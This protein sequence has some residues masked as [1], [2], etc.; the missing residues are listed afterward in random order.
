VPVPVP[1]P[2]PTPVPD[3]VPPTPTPVPN[4]PT[5]KKAVIVGINNYPGAQLNGC[6]NDA[7][8]IKSLIMD[9]YQGISSSFSFAAN[10]IIFIKDEQATTANINQ[11]LSW[12]VADTKTG[13]L[14][15]FWYSG[16]GAEYAGTDVA[17]QPDGMNQVI[18][19]VDFDWS[20]THMIKDVQFK[21]KFGTMPAGVIFN[22]G[23]DS[24]HSGDLIKLLPTGKVIKYRK[25]PNNPIHP[26]PPNVLTQLQKARSIVKKR[27]FING[28]L[29]V[30]YLA[31]CRYN[32]LSA[33]TSDDA[34][35]PCGAMTHGFLM[36]LKQPKELTKT[37]SAIVTDMNTI[38][39]ITD[40]NPEAE[41]SRKDKLILQP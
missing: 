24:C 33:D 29:E 23:S 30:G 4:G 41:G 5:S 20:E 14:R 16:H 3:P 22:W 10:Q 36:A 17:T 38:M 19:P 2:V 40:Q 28:E 11:A 21:A 26:T 1:D 13:D 8:D 34:G 39:T 27:A 9:Q 6:V 37:L 31:G 7:I 18:C 12:L 35:R 32:Q 25:Y 15:F